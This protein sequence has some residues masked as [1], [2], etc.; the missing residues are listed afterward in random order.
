MP[1]LKKSFIQGL[2][3]LTF[4]QE[5]FWLEIVGLTWV[6]PVMQLVQLKKSPDAALVPVGSQNKALWH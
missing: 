3:S 6:F 5:T 1:I 4:L 2:P